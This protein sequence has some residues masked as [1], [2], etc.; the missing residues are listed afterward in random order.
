[1]AAAA[2]K[3]EL[4]LD[5]VSGLPLP[6]L[7]P[8]VAMAGRPS[9]GEVPANNDH[10]H[11]FPRVRFTRTAGGLAL[12]NARVQYVEA[13]D[14]RRLHERFGPPPMPQ[15][16]QEIAEMLAFAAAGYVPE[17]GFAFNEQGEPVFMGLTDED[18][19]EFVLS[20]A[21]RAEADDAA[22]SFLFE[23]VM[24]QGLT[25]RE[26]QHHSRWL[27]NPDE[28]YKGARGRELVLHA[29]RVAMAS[30]SE[31]FA[32]AWDRNLL[33]LATSRDVGEFVCNL[34][35]GKPAGPV[36]RKR[37]QRMLALFATA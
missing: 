36:N 26:R 20:E 13:G 31:R 22:Q 35:L 33:P 11:F 25:E 21:I 7:A 1:M 34:A 30:I 14:H 29:S 6:L 5:P 4:P 9:Q 16:D 18:R 27:A 10:H 17:T 8:P 23:H 12:R 19:R 32:E 24:R 28:P 2:P 3:L 15:S 37:V